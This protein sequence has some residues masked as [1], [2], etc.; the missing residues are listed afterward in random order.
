MLLTIAYEISKMQSK[1]FHNDTNVFTVSK[2]KY[3]TC[4]KEIIA[5]DY[6]KKV[7]I[8]EIVGKMT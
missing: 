6:K 7:R 5:S 3:N 4:P 1:R 8:E 2:K